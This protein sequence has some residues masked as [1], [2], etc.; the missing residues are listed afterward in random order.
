[1]PVLP[2][3]PQNSALKTQNLKL[4]FHIP[5][6]RYSFP[7][8]PVRA[9]HAQGSAARLLRG[10]RKGGIVAATEGRRAMDYKEALAYI[11]GMSWLGSRPGLE[12]V[13]QLLDRLGRPQDRLRRVPAIAAKGVVICLRQIGRAHV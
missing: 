1:M 12:R 13:S 10:G 2:R 4:F 7:D 8:C 5:L 9:F 11:N 3:S 6:L